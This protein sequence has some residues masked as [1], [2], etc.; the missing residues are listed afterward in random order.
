MTAS[1]AR[2]ADAKPACVR[3]A[4]QEEG[5]EEDERREEAGLAWWVDATG[6]PA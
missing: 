2:R 3:K 4:G 5:A 1:T 6:T